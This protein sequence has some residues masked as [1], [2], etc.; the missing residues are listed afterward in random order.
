[1]FVVFD[2]LL[3]LQYRLVVSKVG[4]QAIPRCTELL[5]QRGADINYSFY[6]IFLICAIAKKCTIF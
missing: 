2:L 1:M 3:L 6:Y 4:R 5:L